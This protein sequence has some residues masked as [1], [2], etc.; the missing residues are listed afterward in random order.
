[1]SFVPARPYPWPFHGRF[2]PARTALLVCSGDGGYT[3]AVDAAQRL[4]VVAAEACACGVTVIA[5][6]AAEHRD[7]LPIAAALCDAVVVRPRFGGFTGTDLG[8]VLRG[9]GRTDLL[10]VGFPFELGADC[11]MREANDLGYECLLVADC[12]SPASTETFTGAVRTVQMSGGIFGAVAS[13]DAVL[14]T[15]RRLEKGASSRVSADSV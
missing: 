10:I 1:M 6:P 9:L 14:A 13:S 2:E 3:P 11:T 8:L 7:G 5:L 15:F 4:S 12:C